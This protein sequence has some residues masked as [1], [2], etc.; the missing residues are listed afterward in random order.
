MKEYSPRMNQDAV[1]TEAPI[2][3]S[4]ILLY[5]CELLNGGGQCQLHYSCIKII[6]RI[7]GEF[8]TIAYLHIS[9]NKVCFF[10]MF[11]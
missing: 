9:K 8:Q 5:K 6:I 1:F 4:F 7:V 11:L 10:K 2:S 3:D